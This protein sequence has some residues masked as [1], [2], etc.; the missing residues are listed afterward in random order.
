ML[1]I[2]SAILQNPL[3]TFPTLWKNVA[4]DMLKIFFIAYFYLK[5]QINISP[6]KKPS[7]EHINI[8]R[9][10]FIIFFMWSLRASSPTLFF[11][12]HSVDREIFE[13][14]SDSLQ[15]NL[16]APRNMTAHYLYLSFQILIFS[17]NSEILIFDLQFLLW[18]CLC[19]NSEQFAGCEIISGSILFL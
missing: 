5:I 11:F 13:I 14:S 2:P 17:I 16:A 7:N 9:E 3:I 1:I 18:F 8:K 4:L 19:N 10:L 12:N 15:M 6:S